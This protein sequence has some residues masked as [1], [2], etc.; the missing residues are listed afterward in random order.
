MRWTAHYLYMSSIPD[1]V[2]DL[3]GRRGERKAGKSFRLPA[4][5]YR[6]PIIAEKLY[7]RL[8]RRYCLGS[9]PCSLVVQVHAAKDPVARPRHDQDAPESLTVQ[10]GVLGKP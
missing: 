1:V 7:H 2:G 3:D 5:D 4:L 10:S 6:H 9:A 8:R